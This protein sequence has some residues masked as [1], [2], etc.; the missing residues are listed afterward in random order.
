MPSTLPRRLFVFASATTAL[1]LAACGQGGQQR[2]GIWAA[3]SSTVFP[4]ATRVAENFGR[5]NPEGA[6]PRV[7][8]LGT[9]G[10]IQA[11]CQGLGPTTPDIAN[12]SRR[13]KASEFDLCAE[14]GVTDIIEIK[15]GY[16]GLVVATAR[17]GADLVIQGSDLYMALAKEVP[18]P[19][20]ALIPNPYQTW[21][22][23]RPGLPST[24]IQVYGPP[25]TSGT[26]DSWSELAM[27][28]AAEAMPA[29]AA[30]AES[31]PDR[32]EAVAQTL[33]EDGG[34]IDSGEN[35]NA[36]VQTLERTPGAVGA[37]GYSFLEQN[38][39]Q[40]KPA[41]VNGVLPTLD[42]IASGEYPISRSMFIYVKRAH[43]GVTPG[44]QDFLI[45][46]TSEAA[47]GRG[48]YLQDRGMIPLPG[49]EREAQRAVAA[50]L[51]LMTRPAE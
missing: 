17:S 51:T 39:G 29:L 35:D 11:F 28:P 37:F 6:P 3:G 23:I 8:A 40:V 20:G 43:I 38:I 18:G 48:G 33:R 13:L 46:F 12:A 2:N 42:T 22:Q 50:N 4:F 49:P 27:L 14:N 24:R 41:P 47:V 21:D 15:I 44:L 30:L 45:E 16:D 26:R 25:P 34:W 32:F 10:G 1:I 36:I 7:E 31:D 5:N 9:G 19:D